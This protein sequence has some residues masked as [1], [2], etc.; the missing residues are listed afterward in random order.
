MS[1]DIR[2]RII[3]SAVDKTAKAHSTARTQ[4]SKTEAAYKRLENTF[5]GFAGVSILQ[6]QIR[7]LIQLSDTAVDLESKLK[8][9][10]D[11]TEEFEKAQ[12]DLLKMSLDNG[13]ELESNTILYTRINRALKDLNFT[14][15][16]SSTFTRAIAEGLRISGAGA[17]ESAATIRQLSQAIQSGVL[18]GEELNSVMEQGGRITTALAAGLGVST[19]ELRKLGSEGQLTSEKVVKAILSQSEVIRKEAASM[20]L[21]FER[22]MENWRSNIVT[23]FQENKEFN[24]S[25]VR[26]MKWLNDNFDNLANVAIPAVQVAFVGLMILITNLIKQKIALS[27]QVR[28]QMAEEAKLAEQQRLAAAQ[29]ERF[30]E[31]KIANAAQVHASETKI[32][33]LQTRT[34]AARLQ[35]DKL[36]MAANVRRI[37]GIL[38]ELKLEASLAQSQIKTTT[39]IGERLALQGQLNATLLRTTAYKGQLD[40]VTKK[41]SVTET[42][43]TAAVAAQTTAYEANALAQQKA[44]LSNATMVAGYTRDSKR[45]TELAQRNMD[46]SSGWATS[47]VANLNRVGAATTGILGRIGSAV[48]GL[49][50]LIAFAGYQIAGEFIDMEVAAWAL[51]RGLKRLAVVIGGVF[52]WDALLNREQF[53][54]ALAAFDA[55]TN[56]QMDDML[57]QRTAYNAGYEN[58][59][60]HQAALKKQY[61]EAKVKQEESTARRLMNTKNQVSIAEDTLHKLKME[62][63]REHSRLLKLTDEEDA[64][65]LKARREAIVAAGEMEKAV[66]ASSN[67]SYAKANDIRRDIS[68]KTNEAILEAEMESLAQRRERWD[69]YFKGQ[70]GSLDRNGKTFLTLSQA[71]IGKLRDLDNAAVRSLGKSIAEMTAI[72]DKYLKSVNSGRIEIEQ[73]ERDALDFNREMAANELSELEKGFVAR[74]QI[75]E[76]EAKL[77]KAATLDSVADSEEVSRLRNEAI[78]DLKELAQSELARATSME[79][80]SAEELTATGNKQ[81]AVNLYNEAI[82]QSIEDRKALNEIELEAADKVQEVI[83]QRAAALAEYHSQINK[84]DELVNKQRQLLITAD[85]SDA[86]KKVNE[87]IARLNELHQRNVAIKLGMDST[88]F[89]KGVDKA[90]DKLSNVASSGSTV[91]VTQGLGPLPDGISY[92]STGGRVGGQGDKD[93]VPAMLTPNEWVINRSAVQALEDIYGPDIMHTVNS[94]RLPIMRSTGGRVDNDRFKG[95][96]GF[97]SNLPEPRKYTPTQSIAGSDK[98]T[99]KMLNSIH[100]NLS[101]GASQPNNTWQLRYYDHV[102]GLV[103]K[104]SGKSNGSIRKFSDTSGMITRV[105]VDSL[106]ETSVEQYSRQ[107][108]DL[109]LLIAALHRNVDTATDFVPLPDAAQSTSNQIGSV[110]TPVVQTTPSGPSVPSPI[111]LPQSEAAKIRQAHVDGATGRSLIPNYNLFTNQFDTL[112]NAVAANS[113]IPT[114]TRAG[115]GE[116]SASDKVVIEIKIGDTKSDGVFVNNDATRAMLQELK[117]SGLTNG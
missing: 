18:R 92:Y 35:Q 110:D 3:V 96:G 111:Q 25:I 77:R 39:N 44:A 11:S 41:L 61:D 19:G 78:S 113:A 49:P 97:T 87:L 95:G 15:N 47:T 23:F 89:D 104:M 91:T 54:A 59:E 57:A 62:N 40:A 64:R 4:A 27:V 67:L 22:Q 8:L 20:P 42:Q 74:Q 72:R 1:R 16:D 70:I 99:T 75:T 81:V 107:L 80:Y 12:A 10:T 31:R 28:K 86:E 52:S 56:A 30:A 32:A 109:E 117:R 94:G 84:A 14:M 7:S 58:A 105:L 38:T 50:A 48:F 116:P 112:A 60:K 29:A 24:Q 6:N 93:S 68:Q 2:Q 53:D 46:K 85:T 43:L 63:L 13:S 37:E 34:A 102:L 100:A 108:K 5:I 101:A 33:A 66:L 114:Q 76:A 115:Y 55:E 71:H 98:A 88:E 103:S 9:A 90:T 69:L 36:A 17:Q 45:I 82:Q 65:A 79:K 106:R 83:N 21:T 51:G 73:L 26:S